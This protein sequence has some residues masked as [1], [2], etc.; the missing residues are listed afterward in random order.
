MPKSSALILSRAAR[1]HLRKRCAR[2]RCASAL[3]DQKRFVDQ[4]AGV[5]L[6]VGCRLP[7]RS[8]HPLE[9]CAP[10][11]L[12]FRRSVKPLHRVPF[13]QVAADEGA[14]AQPPLVERLAPLLIIEIVK[15]EDMPRF[16][17]EWAVEAETANGP[18]QVLLGVLDRFCAQS[19]EAVAIN[20]RLLKRTH[21]IKQ[22][23]YLGQPVLVLV[24]RGQLIQRVKQAG[25]LDVRRA[26]VDV[27]PPDKKDLGFGIAPLLLKHIGKGSQRAADQV[28][29]H[30]MRVFQDRERFPGSRFGFGPPFLADQGGD[31][32]PECSGGGRIG[33]SVH[34]AQEL[35]SSPVELL[36]FRKLALLG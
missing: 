7:K 10:L 22:R 26:V 29:L 30:T 21:P 31:K 12:P 13:Q 33:A 2:V 8:G 15:P 11:D 25:R 35:Q 5:R 28:M 23:L 16:G 24:Q 32:V 36:G 14:R 1:R 18:L 3:R 6:V 9:Q 34:L 20:P 17:D 4:G 27:Q 19:I